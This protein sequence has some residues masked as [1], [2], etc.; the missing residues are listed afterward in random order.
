M[1]QPAAPHLGQSVTPVTLSPT[2][3]PTRKPQLYTHSLPESL[4]PLLSDF[5]VFLSDWFHVTDPARSIQVPVTSNSHLLGPQP[6]TLASEVEK[7]AFAINQLTGRARLGGETDLSFNR[8]LASE[9]WKVTG[10][11]IKGPDSSGPSWKRSFMTCHGLP[12]LLSTQVILPSPI[13]PSS[14]S[15]SCSSPMVPH[16]LGLYYRYP[17]F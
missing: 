10:M 12:C 16:L 13:R 8:V 7:V 11:G 14:A 5:L 1:S 3:L 15:Y 2:I 17:S 6:H 4:W 9:L